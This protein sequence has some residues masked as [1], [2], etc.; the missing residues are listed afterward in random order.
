MQEP[1]EPLCSLVALGTSVKERDHIFLLLSHVHAKYSG[2][3]FQQ[4]LEHFSATVF[5]VFFFFSV[6]L[7]VELHVRD[8]S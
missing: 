8:E 2:L 3:V 4:S 5:V 6:L 7:Q 1:Q